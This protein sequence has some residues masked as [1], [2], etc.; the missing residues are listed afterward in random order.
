MITAMVIK[1]Q[2][3]EIFARITLNKIKKATN[4]TLKIY[5]AEDKLLATNT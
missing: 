4:V 3:L 5:S 2:N 1:V